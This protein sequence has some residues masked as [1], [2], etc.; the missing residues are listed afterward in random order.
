MSANHVAKRGHFIQNCPKSRNTPP[1]TY[2][3]KRCKKPG[4]YVHACTF[5]CS[6]TKETCFLCHGSQKFNKNMIAL[7]SENVYMSNAKGPIINED[8][9]LAGKQ[10]ASS[11]NSYNNAEA[12]RMVKYVADALAPQ[13]IVVVDRRY[14]TSQ[15]AHEFWQVVDR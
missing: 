1:D 4:H 3:C 11:I 8:F 14:G 10:H 13:S 5:K 12:K 9:I 6:F 7:E 2:V 15:G